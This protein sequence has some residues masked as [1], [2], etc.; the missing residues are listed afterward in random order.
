MA[1]T[2]FKAHVGRKGVASGGGDRARV[3]KLHQR[4]PIKKRSMCSG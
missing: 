2:S 1:A 4:T 3:A